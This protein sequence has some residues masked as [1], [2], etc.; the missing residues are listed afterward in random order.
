[1]AYLYFWVVFKSGVV[2]SQARIHS[3]TI[4]EL[5]KK[6]KIPTA[7]I[8]SFFLRSLSLAKKASINNTK[9]QING[10]IKKA[11]I[12]EKIKNTLVKIGN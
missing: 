12:L 4:K 8:T 10:V 2:T 6:Y 11:S 1:M 9:T 3:S 5:E 7:Q